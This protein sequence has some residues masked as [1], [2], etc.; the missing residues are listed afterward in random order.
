VNPT[1]TALLLLAAALLLA[2]RAHTANTRLA[3][4]YG[5]RK[6]WSPS[7]TSIRAALAASLGLLTAVTTG[8]PLGPPLGA[9]AAAAAWWL[10]QRLTRVRA[11]TPDPLALAATWDLLA[12]CLRAG[13][14]VPTA[15]IAVADDL[16]DDAAKALRS[17]A[18]LLAMGADPVDAWLPVMRCP[19]TAALA[20]GARHTAR[21][22]TALADAV[23]ALAAN[24]RDSAGDAAEAA[25]QRA[26]VLIAAPLGLCFLPA[27]IC[28]G[29]APVVA[30]LTT[31]LSP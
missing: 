15:V 5:T 23:S 16:P 11:P 31:Q 17:T 12:A 28:L 9:M 19:S 10:V 6:T 22:G 24:V 20:R 7:P 18:D 26:G 13:L 2:F 1:S 4:L 25:A 30:G 21:S 3:T 27:F 8:L 14:P 29:I